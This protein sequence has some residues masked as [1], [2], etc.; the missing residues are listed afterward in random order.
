MTETQ[1]R[2]LQLLARDK[3][4]IESP[5]YRAYDLLPNGGPVDYRTVQRLLALGLIQRDPYTYHY[6]ITAE[7]RKE[8]K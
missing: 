1:K 8:A 2:V 3:A 6:T 4:R 7:G 5:R